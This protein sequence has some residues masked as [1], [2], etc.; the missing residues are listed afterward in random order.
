M[1]TT[2]SKSNK[3]PILNGFLATPETARWLTLGAIVGPIVFTL[4]WLVLGFLSPGFSIFGIWIAPYSP[5]SQPISGLGLG[6]TAPFMNAAFVLSGLLILVGVV[7]IFQSVTEMGAVARWSCTVLLAL[8]PLGMIMDGI[9]T[10]ESFLLHMVGFLLGTGSLVLSFLAV[11]YFFRGIP[12]WRQFGNWLLLGSPLTLVLL[13]VSLTTFDQA[14]AAAGLGVAGLTQRVLVVEA[15][16]WF[17]VMGWLAFRR[18]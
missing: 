9:F 12:R 3:A 15:H 17:V 16:A 4:A 13:I 8:S 10:L 1:S 14:T 2:T 7:G 11:G 5:I 6:L 18:S